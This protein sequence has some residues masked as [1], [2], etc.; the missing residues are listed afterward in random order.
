MYN[1]L[2]IAQY[3]IRYCSIKGYFVSN[4]KL[5]KFLYFVQAEFLVSKGSPCFPETIH[6]WNF[7]PVVPIV[8]RR[9]KIYGSSQIPVTRSSIE[10]NI[11]YNDKLV[12]NAIIDVCSKFTAS[13]LV[14]ITH[15]QTPW[16]EAYSFGRDCVITKNSIK[17]FFEK[18]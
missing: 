13:Q 8:Y 12:I 4:L 6:A 1:V 14:D 11:A 3:I 16:M 9:Y 10:G 7:G 5:Q 18:P 15:N 2:L 17:K